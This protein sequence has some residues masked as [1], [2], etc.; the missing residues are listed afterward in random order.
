MNSSWRLLDSEERSPLPE[1]L[2][3]KVEDVSISYKIT[4]NSGI[5]LKTISI[6]SLTTSSQPK[7]F[8]LPIQL[9]H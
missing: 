2:N 3:E 1:L 7:A 5:K 9:L 8:L 6:L 4:F